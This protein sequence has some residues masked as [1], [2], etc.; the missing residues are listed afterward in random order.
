MTVNA[1][2]ALVD[3]GPDGH[4]LLAWEQAFVLE[5]HSGEQAG[6]ATRAMMKV[7]PDYSYDRASVEASVLL[8]KSRVTEFLNH[9]REQ[10]LKKF[11]KGIVALLPKALSILEEAL[12]SES[13]S[14]RK[15]ATEIVLDRGVGKPTQPTEID[16]GSRLDSLI[17]EIA[18]RKKRSTELL[19]GV[20]G[21]EA[22][23]PQ[24][25]VVSVEEHD[26]GALADHE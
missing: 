15:W 2:L 1:A 25:L 11:R 16:I 18:S 14:L 21:E 13:W 5:Y 7:R 12:N 3:E 10:S 24:E 20:R 8:R 17:K 6:N 9:L 23:A 4:G 22:E 26:G 19:P